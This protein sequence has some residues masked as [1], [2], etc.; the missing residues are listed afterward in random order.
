MQ[1]AAILLSAACA[2]TTHNHSHIHTASE[3]HI[4]RSI[5]SR[6]IGRN[7]RLS[8]YTANANTID[9]ASSESSR[10]GSTQ[11]QKKC[12]VWNCI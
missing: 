9:S 1:S 2:L 3:E 12:R 5:T 7:P 10:A 4:K 8:V 11:C 6:I